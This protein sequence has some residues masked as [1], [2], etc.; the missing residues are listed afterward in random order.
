MPPA[1]V[2]GSGG[3]GV[4]DSKDRQGRALRFAPPAWA[5]FVAA[6]RAGGFDRPGR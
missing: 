5:A 6:S 1:R 3:V 2:T 4:R